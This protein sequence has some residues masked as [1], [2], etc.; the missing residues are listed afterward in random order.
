MFTILMSVRFV[1]LTQNRIRPIDLLKLSI[2][3]FFFGAND[4][5]F[6]LKKMIGFDNVSQ[7][8]SHMLFSNDTKHCR[9]L[10][11]VLLLILTNSRKLLC[12]RHLVLPFILPAPCVEDQTQLHCLWKW[13]I[14]L[15]LRSTIDPVLTYK[16]NYKKELESS[17]D[18]WLNRMATIVRTEWEGVRSRLSTLSSGLS[19]YLTSIGA[20]NTINRPPA[21]ANLAA[22]LSKTKQDNCAHFTLTQLRHTR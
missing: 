19:L 13:D 17:A 12:V 7:L 20:L 4:L 18:V 3:I 22:G 9:I 1:I 2:M 5:F 6:S 8:W 16:W 10:T 21:T 14:L 11:H 15:L